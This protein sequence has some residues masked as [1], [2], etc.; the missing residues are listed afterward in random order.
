MLNT[1]SIQNGGSDFAKHGA[2]SAGVVKWRCWCA[3]SLSQHGGIPTSTAI[4]WGN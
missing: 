3:V 2:P 1:F 4:E